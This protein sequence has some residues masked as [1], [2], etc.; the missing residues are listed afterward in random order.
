MEKRL[1]EAIKDRSWAE[2]V[3]VDADER[4]WK[5]VIDLLTFQQQRRKSENIWRGEVL[6]MRGQLLVK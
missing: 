6:W 4:E 5:T 3:L 2:E 1:N